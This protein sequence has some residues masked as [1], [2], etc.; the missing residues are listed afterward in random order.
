MADSAALRVQLADAYFQNGMHREAV[1]HLVRASEMEGAPPSEVAALKDAFAADGING[2]LRVHIEQLKASQDPDASYALAGPLRI[3]MAYQRLG[4]S[5]AAFEWLEK[6]FATH[7][8]A[9]VHLREQV[10]FDGLH[11]DP[12]FTDLLRRIGLPPL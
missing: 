12:R 8:D 9:I 2:F 5:D 11:R 3:A 6:A 4:D 1:E 7:S 10:A